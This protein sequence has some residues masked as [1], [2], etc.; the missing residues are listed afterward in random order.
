MAATGRCGGVAR[1]LVRGAVDDERSRAMLR[2]LYKHP[3]SGALVA[4]ESR[5]RIFPKGLAEFIRLR[6]D[7]CRMPYCDAPIRHTDHV[8]PAAGG[9]VTSG[10]N[11]QGLCGVQLRQGRA[12][13]RGAL[14]GRQAR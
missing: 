13:A 11:G 5:A 12:V 8:A 6:D 10:V 3:V 2:R 14:T 1:Q 7:T 4:M 9:G